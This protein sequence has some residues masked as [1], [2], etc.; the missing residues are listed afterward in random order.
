MK[1]P[2]VYQP[3]QYEADIYAL[4][5]KS[6]AFAPQSSGKSYSIV[7]PPPNANGNLH[8]G[9]AFAMA[10]Q[11]IAVRYHR[12]KGERVLFVPGADHAGFET[13]VVYE[14]QLNLE[15]KSRFDLSREHLYQQI[16]DFVALNRDTYEL[17]MRR[18]GG[19]FDWSRYVFTLDPKIVQRSFSTFK[20]MWSEGLIYRGQRL[21]NFCTF[22]GTAFADI[23]V[24]FK[25]VKGQ[26]WHIRYPL[27]DGSGEV[28]IATTRPETLLG[29]TAVAVNPKDSRYQSLVG[30][31]VHL[32]LTH[33]EIPIIADQFVDIKFGTGAV[34]VTP[35]HDANDFEVGQR[36][37]L[38]SITVIDQDGKLNQ[39]VP[40]TYRGLT[41]EEGRRKVVKEL[42]EQGLL[43]KTEDHV[44]NVGHCYKCGTVIEPLLREQW[45]V[46]MEP[47]AKKAIRALKG[48][49]VIFYPLSKQRQLI[50]YLENLKDWN[51]SRQIAWGIPIPAFQ[52]VDQPEDWIYDQ[53]VDQEI[54][55]IDDKTYRR[56]PD[57][58]DTW[59]SSSSW[60]YATLDYPDGEDYKHFYPLSLMET[61]YDILMPWVSRM[62]MLGIYVTGQAPFKAVYLHGLVLDE[63]GQKMSKS[64]GNVINP[65][66][67]IDK[68]GSD[69]LRMGIISGQTPGNNQPFDY[70][71]VVGA[72]NFCN[73]LWNIARYIEGVIGDNQDSDKLKPAT[74]A[75]HWILDKLKQCQEA[76]ATHL[77][78]YRF[79]E[80]YTTLYHFVWDD[81]ADWYL[82]A[83]K[84][85][86][87]KSL[88][89]FLLSS[90][91]ILV[92]PFAPFLS[93]TIWQ[94]LVV[95]EDTLLATK[96]Q[97]K[98]PNADKNQSRDFKQIQDII[99]EVRFIVKALRISAATL[100]YNDVPFLSQN[101]DTI[102][103]LARLQNVT[104]VKSGTGLFLTNTP[105]RCWLDIDVITAKGYLR[106]IEIKQAAQKSQIAQLEAR[107]ANKGYTKNA[108]AK[109][110]EQTKSQ[111]VDAK[112]LLVSLDQEYNRF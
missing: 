70:S 92:H 93:E 14:K 101:A 41:V 107:L 100:Y 91:L 6:Q 21:V 85:T 3:Q 9:H 32:P 46:D 84:T 83:S 68:Y 50:T 69:A 53:R 54:I 80:A 16:W 30:R 40:E 59:F 78:N 36:H 24:E 86:P 1:L 33:R 77:D 66:E 97:P 47:L 5:E 61:G 105:Y 71:K 76:S 65:M 79:S 11:D 88:L 89:K 4:W 42:A 96:T 72:R 15:G 49:E 111:L 27:V 60:P 51:I 81:L 67:L 102:K 87:N 99:S 29:D 26:L 75:D 20:Q 108:P 64:R 48:G 2:K 23:E 38:P 34:K 57:V 109:V 10:L 112:R 98:I 17:Q 82:E 39:A 28:V 63:H 13:Q 104:A 62:L 37:D 44:H 35:A 73:K 56:D 74:A 8:L 55:T 110:V 43:V 19:S 52:N 31:S 94:T 22:H 90:V 45:F 18:L 58:F 103:R 7:F 25:E 106:E 95:E 12:Q